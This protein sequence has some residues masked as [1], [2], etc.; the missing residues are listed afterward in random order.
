MPPLLPTL[1]L[2]GAS[3]SVSNGVLLSASATPLVLSDFVAKYHHTSPS[4]PAVPSGTF[5]P[6][7]LRPKVDASVAFEQLDSNHN[8]LLDLAELEPHRLMDSGHFAVPD[9]CSDDDPESRGVPADTFAS[10]HSNIF[11]Q[12]TPNEIL[13]AVKAVDL[14]DDQHV[15]KHECDVLF[16]FSD[17][18]RMHPVSEDGDFVNP[19]RHDTQRYSHTEGG[20][21]YFDGEL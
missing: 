13:E 18:R 7:H 19:M 11:S 10:V 16:G 8:E 3:V 2:L 5:P 4:R 21:H 14:N 17:L 15:S 1:L 12:L 6:P 9:Y 20:I